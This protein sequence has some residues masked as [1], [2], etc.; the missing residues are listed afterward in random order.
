MF[1]LF[2]LV[3]LLGMVAASPVVQRQDSILLQDPPPGNGRRLHP[4]GQSDLCVMVQKGYAA[5]N[6]DVAISVCPP[7]DD[8]WTESSLWN[9]ANGSTGPISVQSKVGDFCLTVG[10]N[11]TSGSRVFIDYCGGQNQNWYYSD[12]NVLKLDGTNLCLDVVEGS[13]PSYSKPY[14]SEK[15][16]QVWEC[17]E[18]NTNQIFFETPYTS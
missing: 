13:G 5:H 7:N 12:V 15:D 4:Y 17:V 14:G 8:T 2:A 16:L 1:S 6:T 18:G 11:P 10:E 3:P 9:V